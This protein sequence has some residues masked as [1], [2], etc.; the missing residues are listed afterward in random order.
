VLP[1]AVPT[2]CTTGRTN[3]AAR[4][5]NF[6]NGVESDFRLADAAF[7]HNDSCYDREYLFQFSE[8]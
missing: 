3:D 7:S 1:S 2:V 4:A 8:N 5:Q 6:G